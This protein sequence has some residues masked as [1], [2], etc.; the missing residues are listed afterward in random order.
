MLSVKPNL[1]IQKQFY[2]MVIFALRNGLIPA[3]IS[4]TFLRDVRSHS[5]NRWYLG[6]RDPEL[7]LD[8]AT[9]LTPNPQWSWQQEP[10]PGFGELLKGLHGSETKP[11]RGL[12][13]SGEGESE[14]AHS[15]AGSFLAKTTFS[16]MSAQISLSGLRARH[17]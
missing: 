1:H 5:M 11:F 6:P 12:G 16:R 10:I 2:Q 17:F 13:S 9:S 15:I 3:K 8:G 14:R 7:L 4:E